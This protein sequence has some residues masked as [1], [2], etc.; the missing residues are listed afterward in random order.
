MN[1]SYHIG[2]DADLGASYAILPG[3]PGRVEQIAQYL[4]APEFLNFQREYKSYVGL[5]EGERVLLMSTGMGGPSTAIAVEELA[6]LGVQKL[7]RVG[8]CGG[9]Q[10][11]IRPGELILAQAAIRQEGTSREYLPLE[12]PAV[13]DF[14][15][16]SR[17]VQAAQVLGQAYRLG[18]VHCKDS[19]YGQHSPERMPIA[20]E[21]QARW[22]AWKQ[23]G[24]LASE[25]ESAALFT[26]AQVRRLQAACI[27][28]CIW[29]QERPAVH[30]EPSSHFE[31]DGLLKVAVEALRQDILASR[32][33]P[34]AASLDC[35]ALQ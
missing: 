4:E 35:E 7:L 5:L 29:N 2:L 23:G 24:C 17:L 26:V 14:G 32:T 18:V 25:M 1:S 19:F 6:Q 30:G 16:T 8:T 9:M 31:L 11:E 20:Q 15:L 10:P 27:L 28:L 22:E 13:A 3:D 12:F 33:V 34:A 21:L